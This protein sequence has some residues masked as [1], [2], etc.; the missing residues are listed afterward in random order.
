ML[1]LL[2]DRD[3]FGRRW[4]VRMRPRPLLHPFIQ[5]IHECVLL[6]LSL[7]VRLLLHIMP[8]YFDKTPPFEKR[9]PRY[10]STAFKYVAMNIRS[11]QPPIVIIIIH[12]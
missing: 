5:L 4:S 11:H 6:L 1:L 8:K 2:L 10:I 9:T 12:W 7:P 3:H